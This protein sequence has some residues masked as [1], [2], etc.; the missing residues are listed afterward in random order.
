VTA[1][2]TDLATRV[3]ERLRV[4]AAGETPSAEDSATVTSYYSGIFAEETVNG[5]FFWD[6]D[7]IP[8]EAFEAL[9]DFI[10][11]RLGADF[12]SQRPDLEASGMV[13]LRKLS[14]VGSTGLIVTGSY[15]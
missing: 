2:T 3:L 5:L 10:A 12:G 7:D 11:G 14:A 9:A 4:T 6:E 15:F 1:T 8:D 13:R